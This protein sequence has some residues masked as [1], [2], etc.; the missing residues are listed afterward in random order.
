[1]AI[2]TYLDVSSEPGPRWQSDE[3]EK[4]LS[5]QRHAELYLSTEQGRKEQLS[6]RAGSFY[7]SWN[8]QAGQRQ[9]LKSLSWADFELFL[10]C[11]EEKAGI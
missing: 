3:T 4:Q 11:D 1:M 10:L 9:S 2:K 5:A 8:T 6:L 7:S